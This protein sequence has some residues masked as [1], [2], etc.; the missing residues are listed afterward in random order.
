M[1]ELSFVNQFEKTY[2]IGGAIEPTDE[3]IENIVNALAELTEA[4]NIAMPTYYKSKLTA[5]QK[6]I[7]ANKGWNLK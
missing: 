5:E 4:Q 6:Q 2:D 7:I 3:I 1:E